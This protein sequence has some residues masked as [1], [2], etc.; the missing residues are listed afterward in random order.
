MVRGSKINP[1]VQDAFQFPI[2]MKLRPVVR[3]DRFY[4]V[5]F[6]PKQFNGS[7]QCQF[8]GRSSDRPHPDQSCLSFHHRHQTCLAPAVHRV[9]LPIPDPATFC[10][11]RR[12]LFYQPFARKSSPAVIPPIPFPSPF[13]PSAQVPPQAPA[14]PLVRPYPSVNGLVAH[15]RL[16]L[17]LSSPNNLFRT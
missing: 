3:G 7:L 12:P 13:P 17:T 10:H 11:H 16:P 15:D 9:N 5:A 14:F 6:S 4:P 2:V 8:L 1:R